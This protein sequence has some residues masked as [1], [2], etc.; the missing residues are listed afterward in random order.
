MAFKPP[1]LGV[2]AA[3]LN[4]ENVQGNSENI[5]RHENPNQKCVKILA[6]NFAHLFRTKR[7]LSLLLRAILTSLMQK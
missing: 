5:P 1:F 4:T 6:P 7:R 3:H 2:D